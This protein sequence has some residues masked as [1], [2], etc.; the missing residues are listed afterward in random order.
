MEKLIISNAEDFEKYKKKEI[1]PSPYM[2]IDQD[3]INN[4]AD[5]TN[6][7]QW[8]HCDPER[9]AKESPFGKTIAHGYLTLSL[10]PYLIT[11]VLDVRNYKQ[12]INYGVQNIKFMEPVPVN[13]K[14]RIKTEIHDVKQIRD[15]TKVQFNVI[16]ELE[17]SKKPALKGELIY[18]YKF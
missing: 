15:L 13:G 4:F 10:I 17:G 3:R 14:I 7:H 18:L 12:A 16:I 8:I 1:H 9:A 5:A 6:D 11:Q 2:I